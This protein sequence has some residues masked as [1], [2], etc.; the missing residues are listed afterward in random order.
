MQTIKTKF[1]F[2]KILILRAWM[3]LMFKI[4]ERQV[5]LH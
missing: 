3:N 2:N 4:K 1:I 5:H